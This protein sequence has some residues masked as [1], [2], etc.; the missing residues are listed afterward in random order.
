MASSRTVEFVRHY[1]Q[2]VEVTFEKFGK[3]FLKLPGIEVH[4]VS[5]DGKSV[6]T[7]RGIKAFDLEEKLLAYVSE[8][9]QKLVSYNFVAPRFGVTRYT[10]TLVFTSEEGN[11]SKIT[12]ILTFDAVEQNVPADFRRL[13]IGLIQNSFL[14]SADPTPPPK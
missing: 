3:D 8:G 11:T 2:S 4:L 1:N 7:V 14:P 13:V 5:G 12:A 9:P 6:G 10:A